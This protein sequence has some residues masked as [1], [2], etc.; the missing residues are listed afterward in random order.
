MSEKMTNTTGKIFRVTSFGTSHGKA[1]GAVIEE[2][3]KEKPME[4]LLQDLSTTPIKNL[5][6]IPS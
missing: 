1:L 4:H 6:I 3:L 5:K 2:S